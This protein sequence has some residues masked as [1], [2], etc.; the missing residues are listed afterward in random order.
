[1]TAS[2]FDA[3]AGVAGARETAATSRPMPTAGALPLI[4][5]RPALP[6]RLR[7][8]LRVPDRHVAIALAEAGPTTL[9]PGDHALPNWPAPAPEVILLDAG[10]LPLDLQWDALPA[11]DGEP[12]TLIVSAEAVVAD[13]LRLHA[14]WLRLNPGPEWPLPAD[15]LAGRL[16][17]V[18]CEWAAGYA[19]TDLG[20]PQVQDAVV[21]ALREPLARELGRYGLAL[22]GPALA[23]KV[24]GRAAREA[25]VAAARS[26]RDLAQDAAMAEG[27]AQLETRDMF[28]DRIAAW[29]AQTGEKLSATTVETLWRQ[30]APDGL[31]LSEPAQVATALT[32]AAEELEAQAAGQEA[33]ALPAERRFAQMQARLDAP[34]APLPDTPSHRLDRLYRSLRLGAAT[35][36]C[37]WAARS[38]FSHG[39]AGDDVAGFVV[40][41]VGLAA[42]A[43]GVGVAAVTYR[44]AQTRAAPYWL[45][46]Q[47]WMAGLPAGALLTEA[48]AQARRYYLAADAL[49]IAALVSG[50]LFWLGSLPPAALVIPLLAFVAAFGLALA[51]RGRERQA[52]RQV[53]ALTETGS[54]PALPERRTVDDLVRRQV[55]AHLD[56]AHTNLEE[57]GGK[58]FRLGPA[59]QE[60][61]A[62][63]RLLRTGPLARLQE[64]AQV[65]HYR[66]AAYFN[67]VWAP[68]AHVAQMLDLDDDL[69]GRAR[70][71]A[72]DSEALYAASADGDAAACATAAPA[73][74]KDIN[75]LRRV[76]GERSAFIEES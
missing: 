28:L 14:A 69:L 30:V 16:H 26:A 39:F 43:V 62:T 13:P 18:A 5:R 8:Q 65:V 40:E 71:L 45:A 68:D 57:A 72:L 27:L 2:L 64:E 54:R 32:E 36:G 38:V 41:G 75:Q 37:A 66:D 23:A 15:L 17:T 33:T 63:L 6:G 44:Q 3:A 52:R 4:A 42:A 58:L 61:S 60:V 56:R 22:A 48:R 34:V 7:K 10:P 12:V 20:R 70:K 19:A 25:A 21:R 35:V 24:V 59:G 74:D 29:E 31:P 67:T 51:G 49:I 11:G 1:M 46:V 50:L 73:L 9:G 47:D 53:D 76:F 55:R